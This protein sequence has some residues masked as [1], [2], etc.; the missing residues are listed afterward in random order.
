MN[1]FLKDVRFSL[2]VLRKSPGFTV[3]AILTLALAIGANAV[4]FGILN[5]LVLRPL[6]VARAESLYGLEEGA[7]FGWQSYPDYLDLRERNRTFEDLAAFGISEVALDTGKDP[8]SVYCYE[9]SGNYFDVLGMQQPYLGRYF[10]S[11]DEHGPNSAPYIVLSYTYWHS[12]FQDDRSVVGRIVRLNKHPFTVIGVTP[13]GFRG[14]L[15]FFSPEF[16]VPMANQELLDGES[17]LNARGVKGIMEVI[18]HLK[19]GITT[20]QAVG[21]L[22][23]IGAY[24]VST[25]P[26]DHA[27]KPFTLGRPGFLGNAMGGPVQAFVAALM[28]LAGLILLAACANLGSLFAARAADRA[29]EVALRL[30]LGSNRKRIL[31][32][33]LT[34]ALLVSIIGGTVG[35]LGSLVL[36]GRLS[37]WQPVP[38]YPMNLPVTPDAK[39]YVVAL[40]LSLVSG[41]LFGIIPVRQVLQA[42]PYEVVKSG[43]GARIGRR[44]TIRDILLVGQIAICA[45]LV[46]CSMVAIRG[47]SRSLHGNFGFDPQNTMLAQTDLKMSG[48]TGD[49][50]PA[51][52]RRM[53]EALQAV[54]GI[55]SV[56]SINFPPLS[57]G[58]DRTP[59]FTDRTTDLSASNSAGLS[60]VYHISPGYFHAADTTLLAG[61]DFSWDDDA[62]SPQVAV[63]N[64]EFAKKVLG[65]A[66]D[67]LGRYFKT[68]DGAR[69]Q[70]VGLVEDG[71]YLVLTEEAQPAVFRPIMQ[72]PISQTYLVVRSEREPLQLA[73]TVRSTLHELDSALPLMIQP[74]SKELDGALFSSRIATVA[75]GVL[76]LMGAMLTVTGIFGMAAYS[77]SKRLKELGIRIALGAQRREVLLAAL[78]RP[79]KLLALGSALGLVL[80]ALATQVLTYLVYQATLRDPLVLGCVVLTMMLL[81]LIATWIPAQRALSVNPVNLLREE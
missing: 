12:H 71:K 44:V 78:G 69:V 10:H 75:L 27:L 17:K 72:S 5:A 24:L 65:S 36:L 13:P 50:V 19:P 40:V 38:R 56:A 73:G 55:Q 20:A 32:Q 58:G 77:V 51:M 21:D 37:A 16:F 34:E 35:L 74:W 66:N 60:M 15:L 61:R 25:Y 64:R 67:A 48:Y 33:L 63:V 7:D 43:S 47:L 45:V 9:T 80:G 14:T 81:G 30:A 70:V 76:G 26:K 1:T 23:S 8:S 11:A 28:L 2:R 62:N 41:F 49:R 31:R 57:M 6:N 3:T 52:Q 42:N 18:G 59:V 53:I 39:V 29:H 68:A 79:V 54:P 22:N 4:V 46:I